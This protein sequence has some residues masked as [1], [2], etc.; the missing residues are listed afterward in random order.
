[1]HYTVLLKESIELLNIRP[2]GVYID[3]TF[4]RGG[5]SKAILQQLGPQG[6][7]IAF[8]KDIEAVEFA[9]ANINDTRLSLIQDSFA[10]VEWHLARLKLTKVDGILLD[11]GVSSPQ[12]DTAERG[13][14]FRLDSDLDMRMDNTSGVSCKEW[15][16][17]VEEPELAR[18]LW[19]YGEEKFARKIARNIVVKRGE[20]PITRTTQLAKIIEA[21]VP[22]KEKGQH[23]ATRSFQAMRIFINNELNDLETILAKLPA[24]LKVGARVVVISF[25]SLEDRMVKT[26]FNHL[27]QQNKLPKW[28][29]A[30][31][32]APEYKVIAK[33]VKA[34]S[35]EL[36]QNSR[37]RSAI[38]RCLERLAIASNLDH[39]NRSA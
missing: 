16:N 14:S 33:K 9:K 21:S 3:G 22:F 36:A 12:L 15:L 23:P 13:F 6:K 5:H 24:I 39:K 25:H 38:M 37:S 30:E 10:N 4:G 18:I 32:A 26:A 35:H 20:A 11:L 2:D 31:D 17:M 8:D 28:V 1:M 34:D 19:Q 29:M 27:C 7:L